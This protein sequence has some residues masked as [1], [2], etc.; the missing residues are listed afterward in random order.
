LQQLAAVQ[1]DPTPTTLAE[2]TISYAKAKTSYFTALRDAVL[3][4]ED[5]AARCRGQEDQCLR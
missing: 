3:E 1:G 4:L 5:I 2:K